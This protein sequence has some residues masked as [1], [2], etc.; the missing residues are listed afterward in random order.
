MLADYQN[1]LVA[2]DGSENGEK[3]FLKACRFAKEY[4]ANLVLAHVVDFRTFATVEHYNQAIIAEIERFGKQLLEDYE[5]KAKEQGV[6]KV[7]TVLEF[8]SPRQI[9]PKEIAKKYDVDLI[10]TGATGL[11]AVERA[12]LGSV[13]EAIT[14]NA[15]CDV[16]IV[17]SE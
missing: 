4:D 7:T 16:L 8:G 1:I 14:R 6:E 17:R 12:M 3:A 11:N 15:P 10:L 13:S 2:V 9:I 5:K